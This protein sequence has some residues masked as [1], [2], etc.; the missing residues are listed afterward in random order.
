M[1]LL[2]NLSAAAAGIAVFSGSFAVSGSLNKSAPAVA[3]SI[4]GQAGNGNRSG[5]VTVK[6]VDNI[7]TEGT[8]SSGILAKSIAG[9]GG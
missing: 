7:W 2:L 8:G 5:D 9:G 3:L 6:S 4:G 1:V